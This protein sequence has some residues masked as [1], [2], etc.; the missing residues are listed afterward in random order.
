MAVETQRFPVRQLFA[1]GYVGPTLL[2]WLAFVCNLLLLYF[3]SAWLPSVVHGT[4]R[5]LELANL[6][7]SL[8]QAGGIVGALIL[9]F[10]CD[11]TG[12]PQ[13]VLAC[14][15]LGAAACCVALGQVG[16]DTTLLMISAAGA[17]FCVVGGQIAGNAVV[18]T[19]YPSAAR[20]TGVGWALGIGRL[21]SIAGPLLGGALIGLKVSTPVLF[22]IFAIPALLGSL[23]VLLVKRA[24]EDIA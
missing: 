21:G 16:S 1:P 8:Y 9:A 15:F 20:A 10:L 11:R 14:A 17:G 24:P 13:P 18:G 3:L 7:T 12:R 5:S 2:I 6:T 23:S 22:T 4:G 19:Y